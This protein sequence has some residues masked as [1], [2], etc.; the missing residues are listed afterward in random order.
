MLGKVELEILE[1]LMLENRPM[2]ASEI[3]AFIDQNYQLIGKRTEKLRDLR[4]VDK[5]PV[6]NITL[7]TITDTAKELYFSD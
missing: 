3:S 6:N 2:R 1:I 5:T 4:L 7:N